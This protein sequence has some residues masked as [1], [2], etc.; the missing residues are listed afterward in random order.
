MNGASN[1]ESIR[2]YAF[3]LLVAF[4]AVVVRQTEATGVFFTDCLGSRQELSQSTFTATDAQAFYR[5]GRDGL[6][7][8]QMEIEGIL[9]GQPITDIDE[10]TN[11]YTTLLSDTTVMGHS[12]D[13]FAGRFCE[14]SIT[15]CPLNGSMEFVYA[16]NVT[17]GAGYQFMSFAT[18]FVVVDPNGA[19]I[20]CINVE[21]TPVMKSYAWYVLVFGVVGILIVCVMSGWLNMKFRVLKQSWGQYSTSMEVDP[22]GRYGSAHYSQSAMLLFS[23]LLRYL[24]FQ[25]LCGCLTL[26]YPGFYQPVLSTLSWTCLLFHFSFVSH[27]KASLNDG[28]YPSAPAQGMVKMSRV[29]QLVS[30]NDVWPSFIVWLICVVVTVM[31]IA[32]ASSLFYHI[33]K[34]RETRSEV[35]KR[36]SEICL[37]IFERLTCEIFA[38]PLLTLSLFQLTLIGRGNSYVTSDVFALIVILLWVSHALWKTVIWYKK[39]KGDSSRER[40]SPTET[41][42]NV[43]R[44]IIFCQSIA[45]GAIQKS[46][47]AQLVLLAVFETCRL[48]LMA[49]YK[50][51]ADMRSPIR[52]LAMVVLSSLKV[53]TVLMLTCFLHNLQINA[54]ARGW[55][56]YVLLLID[57]LVLLIF[58]GVAVEQI[59]WCLRHRCLRSDDPD[60]RELSK[61]RINADLSYQHKMDEPQQ[62]DALPLMM[63]VDTNMASAIRSPGSPTTSTEFYRRPKRQSLSEWRQGTSSPP[64]LNEEDDG[65]TRPQ[66][67]MSEMSTQRP[68]SL[69]SHTD[70]AVREA[71][72]YITRT[73]D[74]EYLDYEG[75]KD[76]S[77]RRVIHHEWDNRKHVDEQPAEEPTKLAVVKNL[78]NGFKRAATGILHGDSQEKGEFQVINRGPIR[79][80]TELV[81]YVEPRSS[82]EAQSQSIDLNRVGDSELNV[83]GNESFDRG[84]EQEFDLSQH[85]FDE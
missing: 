4:F 5:K 27:Y 68:T 43:D 65:I 62:S 34:I 57:A 48:A 18:N 51:S 76:G 59:V 9:K 79:P 45:T 84:A 29:V 81:Q 23:N 50:P 3:L 21:A 24:Q 77:A 72:I 67:S 28:L 38:F 46:G 69:Y 11:T 74:V 8:L 49:Y 14:H 39:F 17:N 20:A 22:V 70:Y 75:I 58:L 30:A 52:S 73:M 53:A 40:S 63:K 78:L 7:L 12:I 15:G 31:V 82:W 35:L 55:I 56:G 13:N 10:T 83:Q 44:G 47:T 71:D 37:S 2:M 36:T 61:I 54:S 16:L 26:A 80:S 32:T 64:L 85:R 1:H 19:A 6:Y 66:T 42:V 25:F 60:S 33:R 41:F